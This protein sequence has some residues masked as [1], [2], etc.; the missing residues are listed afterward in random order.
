MSQ[1]SLKLRVISGLVL[2]CVGMIFGFILTVVQNNWI[3]D[4]A[5]AENL[6]RLHV[7]ANSNSP[8][9]QDL[10]LEVRD[11]IL[12]ATGRMLWDTEEKDGA[13]LL[14][15]ENKIRLEELAQKVI[16]A[17]G[18]EYPVEVKIG[19]FVFPYREYGSMALPEGWYDAVRVE[20][21]EA[22]GDNWWCVLFPPLCLADLESAEQNLVKVSHEG[23]SETKF[24]LRSKL[25]EQVAN[26]RYAQRL[27]KW[28]QASAAGFPVLAN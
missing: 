7:I 16:F 18:Y 6:I 19:Q 22:R 2:L 8:Q 26:T 9:D 20:I 15:G 25:W 17:H 21:G 13:Y 3:S 23:N 28:W 27:Q 11:A 1:S 14:L 24:V 5:Y 10:K 12:Q 4:K